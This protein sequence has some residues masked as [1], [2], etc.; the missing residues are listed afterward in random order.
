M[1]GSYTWY[2]GF[3]VTDSNPN[4]YNPTPGSNP[5][6]VRNPGVGVWGP[7]TKIINLVIHDTGQGMDPTS[8]ATDSEYYGNIIY[9]NGWNA[10]DRGHGHGIYAQKATRAARS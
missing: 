10:P 7:G 2:W 5:V 1:N 8:V 3:E 4:R 9:Y 6:D